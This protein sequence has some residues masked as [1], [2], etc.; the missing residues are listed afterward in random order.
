MKL[1]TAQKKRIQFNIGAVLV[2]WAL[3]SIF[4]FILTH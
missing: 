4:V 2:G 3:L 1:T